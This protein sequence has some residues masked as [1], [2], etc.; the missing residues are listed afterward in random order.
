MLATDRTVIAR[1]GGIEVAAALGDGVAMFGFPFECIGS[2]AVRE[3]VAGAVLGA[4]VPGDVP[5]DIEPDPSDVPWVTDSPPDID[6]TPTDTDPTVGSDT[7]SANLGESPRVPLSEMGGCGCNSNAAT[8]TG[9]VM[10]AT[11]LG[12]WRR[13]ERCD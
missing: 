2:P 10:L 9:V 7:G 5:E 4:L 6:T 13:R 8:P 12:L 11:L 1:Y 3:A